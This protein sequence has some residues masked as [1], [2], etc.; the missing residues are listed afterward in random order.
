MPKKVIPLLPCPFCGGEAKVSSNDMMIKGVSEHCA[1]V[2]C[3][4]CHM[5]TSYML[6]SKREH[7]VR[8]A[9]NAWNERV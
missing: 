1:W 3:T 4:K 6:R 2:W 7:Y 9:A 5:R 8:D